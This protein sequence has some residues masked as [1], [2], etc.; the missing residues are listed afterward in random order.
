[1]H[2]TSIRP[3]RRGTRGRNGRRE[4]RRRGDGATDSGASAK[5]SGKAKEVAFVDESY[6]IRIER[7]V[8]SFNEDDSR[9]SHT[10]DAGLSK[11]ERKYVHELCKLYGLLSKSRGKG[12]NRSV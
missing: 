1:M 2:K 6:K 11:D 3:M 10:F 5:G 7:L 8:K 12:A 9:Q 4:G